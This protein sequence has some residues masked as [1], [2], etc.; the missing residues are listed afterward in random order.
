[1]QTPGKS[2]LCVHAGEYDDPQ[3]GGMTTPIFT[4]SS[5]RYDSDDQSKEMFYPRYMNVPTQT[6]VAAKLAR[7]ESPA[8][9]AEALML[10]SGMAAISGTLMALLG[11]GDHVVMQADVYGGTRHLAA[12]E[13]PR[14]GIEVS[15]AAGTDMQAFAA[16]IKPNTRAIYVETPANPLLSVV[17]ISAVA[18]LARNA[19]LLS[20]CDS[21]FGTPINQ[22]PLELGIDVVL[23]SCTK[24]LNGHSDLNA[25]AVVCSPELMARIKPAL[26]S[27]GATLNVYDC[28]LLERG[29]KTLALRVM[30]HNENGQALAE[31]LNGH[32]KVRRVYY[33]GL[34]SHPGHEVAAR[35]MSGFGGMLSF[36]MHSVAQAEAFAAKLKHIALAVSLGGVESLVCFPAR[37]SHAKMTSE[38]RRAAGI[39]NTLLR[40]SAGVEDT[41]DLLADVAEALD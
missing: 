29:M 25:G 18:L 5:F 21:T 24:Y 35:Q 23:H 3:T 16:A 27:Y 40:I 2:T 7:L 39:C 8:G 17:D 1:M 6:A 31:L 37:T 20:F 12:R 41:E 32:P 14:L 10:G 28:F 33:P 11:A 34:A 9:G 15:F 30:R 4:S 38:E 36:E 26:I 19:G 22:R 13:L